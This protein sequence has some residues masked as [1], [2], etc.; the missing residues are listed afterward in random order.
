MPF[1]TKGCFLR[2]QKNEAA[3]DSHIYLSH[4]TRCRFLTDSGLYW[5]L[6]ASCSGEAPFPLLLLIK[7]SSLPDLSLSH[8]YYFERVS[9]E[10]TWSIL[11]PTVCSPLLL[12]SWSKFGE[13]LLHLFTIE[14]LE[15]QLLAPVCYYCWHFSSYYFRCS[16]FQ[17]QNP[18]GHLGPSSW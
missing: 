10:L 16:A 1:H 12:S 6:Y 15:V 4:I 14:F 13:S 9:F 3:L 8:Y 2:L 11:V 17:V 18:F 7:L 5:L